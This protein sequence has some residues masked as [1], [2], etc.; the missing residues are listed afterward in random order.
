M[1]AF[2]QTPHTKPPGSWYLGIVLLV[3]FA[4]CAYYNTFYLAK[5]YYRDGQRAEERNLSDAPSPEAAQKYDATIRQCA[6]ILVEYPKSKWVDDALYFMGAA[7]YGKGD[8]AGAIKKFGELRAGVPKSPFVPDSRLMEGLA[9]YRRKEFLEAETVFHEV[10]TTYPDLKRKWELYYYGAECEVGLKNFPAAIAWYKRAVEAADKKRRRADALRREGDAYFASAKYDSAQIVYAD[11]LKAEEIGSR[12]L[13][14]A[15]KR[16]D[17]LEQLKRFDEALQ[18]YESWKPFAVN[19]KRQGEIMIRINAILA[20]KGKTKEAIAGYRSLVDQYPHTPVAYEAQ[21][22]LGY[23]YE[24]QLGDLDAAGREYDKLKE[25]PGY[26]EFQM[27]GKRRSASLA[28]IKQYRTTL[29]SDSTQARARSA[30]LLAELYYFQIEKVDSALIQYEAVEQNFPKSPYAPKAAFARLWIHTHDQGDTA[31]AA[32]ITDVIASRYRRTRYAESA[33]YLWKRWSGRTDAR[34]ALLDSMLANPDT[35]LVRERAEELL[36]SITAAAAADSV[37][38][39]ST[40]TRPRFGVPLTP[41]EEAR[42][43]SL[44][45]YSRELLRVQREGEGKRP[46]PAPGKVVPPPAVADTSRTQPPPLAPPDTSGTIIG[47]A[48]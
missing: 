4:G 46:I 42:R 14:L 18:F 30:F 17:A 2:M 13:D 41:A 21:F 19:E 48:R 5:R 29:A 32:A 40:S 24:S 27:Q 8:Y 36:P 47:P 20:L 39:D 25:E 6:K 16:G 3:A 28:T 23:L 37:K 33:L 1:G 9:R 26:S 15:F 35:T 11:C 44:A 34:T 7:M 31:A 12:R 10:E 43:D 45:A 22:R 38:A